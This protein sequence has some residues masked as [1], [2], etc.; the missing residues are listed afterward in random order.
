MKRLAAWVLIWF[1]CLAVAVWAL[2]ALPVSAVSGTGRKGWRLAVAY[3]QLGNVAAGGDED[4]TFSARCWRR[5]DERRYG[6]LVA[7]IDWG[8]LWFAGEHSHCRMA[9]EKEVAKRGM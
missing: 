2:I 4:E 9:Y 6:V 8:F 5:R 7:V 1:G 3:D